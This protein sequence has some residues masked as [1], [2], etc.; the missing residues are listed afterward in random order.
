VSAVLD[1]HFQGRL[2]IALAEVYQQPGAWNPWE[3]KDNEHKLSKFWRDLENQRRYFAWLGSVLGVRDLEGWYSVK[4]Q[5]FYAHGGTQLMWSI[6]NKSPRQAVTTL[7]PEHDWKP[8]RFTRV[9]HGYWDLEQHRR[10]F[11]EWLAQKLG[12]SRDLSGW[13]TVDR[14][15]VE[16]HGGRAM[17]AMYYKDSVAECVISLY[18]E[19][20][21]RRWMF[22][23]VP[24]HFVR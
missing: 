1:E 21:W 24:K 23:Q 22:R 7:F 10:E 2:D 14:G 15:V 19:H 8:W 6:Y 3:F 11:L 18:P 13:Y 9:P 16:E 17:L 4:L 12:F 20:T 5:D